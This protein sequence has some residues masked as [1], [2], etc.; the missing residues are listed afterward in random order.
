M[1]KYKDAF[2]RLQ[3][4]LD[5][6]SERYGCY[7]L[8]LYLDAMWANIRYGV[9]PNEYIGGSFMPRVVENVRHSTLLAIFTTMNQS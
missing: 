2:G 8:S 7:K 9:T 6:I 4:A 1:G 5:A 3:Y